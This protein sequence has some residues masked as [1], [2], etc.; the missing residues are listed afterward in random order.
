M[1]CIFCDDEVMKIDTVLGSPITLQGRGIC[2]AKC[3]EKDL[4]ERRIFGSI[5]MSD[6]TNADLNELKD[7]VLMEVNEREGRSTGEA[8]LF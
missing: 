7:L 5:C 6:L 3:A 4:I 1:R 8:E 2:H